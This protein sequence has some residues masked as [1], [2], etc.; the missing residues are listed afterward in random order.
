MRFGFLTKL[1][2]FDSSDEPQLDT[3]NLYE[4]KKG[5]QVDIVE[6]GTDDPLASAKEKGVEIIS[7][8]LLK[9]H[10]RMNG[11]VWRSTTKGR[12]K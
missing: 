7:E 11:G 12:G 4:I 2:H 3:G 6:S 9:R 5:W 1:F 10:G 8:E